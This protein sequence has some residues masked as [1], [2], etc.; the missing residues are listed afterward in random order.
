M[1][2]DS[3]YVRIKLQLNKLQQELHALERQRVNAR[4]KRGLA[5]LALVKDKPRYLRELE[6]RLSQELGTHRRLVRLDTILEMIEE[7]DEVRKRI[8]W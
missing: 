6:N 2:V 7:T 3:K 5:A 4:V 1:S 8:V